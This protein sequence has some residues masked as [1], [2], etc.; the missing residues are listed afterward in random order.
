M[1]AEQTKKTFALKGIGVSPGVVIGRAY[2]FDPL[3]SQISFYKLKKSSSIPKEIQRFKKSLK[4]SEIQLL[5]IQENL[6]KSRITEPL[7]VIDVH[8]LILKDKKFSNRT[9]KYIRRLGINAE[10]A[11]RLTLDHYKQIFEGVGDAYIRD[12]ISDVQYVGQRILRNLSGEKREIVLEI[13]GEVIVIAPDLSPADTAQ[14]KMDKVIGFATDIGGRTS[15]TAIVSRAM[16]LPA[17]AG[18]GNI[19]QLV[20]T[21]DELIVDGIS[22]VV[23]VNPYPEMIKRYE[24][25]KL[26][27][28]AVN[29]EYMKYAK[30]PAVTTDDYLVQIGGNIEFVE[31][32]PSA[33]THG[34]EYIG[35]YRTEFL[36]I[37]R[38]DLP[39]EEDHFTNYRQVVSA[40]ELLWSTIRT[41]DLGGDKLYPDQKHVKELN[42][43]MGLRA[44]R[45]CLK[46]TELFKTQLRAIWRA[47]A[48]GKVKILFPMIAS[49]EEIREAKKLLEEARKELLEQGVEI[50]PKMEVGAM[51]EVPAAVEIADKLA[52]EVD[53]FSIGT[54]DL[55][56]YALAID[57]ANERLTY[58]YEPLH[59]AILRLIKRVVDAAHEVK[60]RVAM[61]GE[62]AGDPLYALILLG[63]ELDELSMNHL[64]IPRIKRIIRESSIKESKVL[65]EKA[66]TFSTATEVRAYVQDYMMGRFPDEFQKEV[67]QNGS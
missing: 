34:A 19:T 32:I 47:S 22:G 50:A 58:L 60:I 4:D 67:E 37:S 39:T 28:S 64:A 55:T 2:R 35:L 20:K 5:E 61:C 17:V 49:M 3:D 27:F 38:H 44:I 41:F 14:M 46:E 24:E 57:R 59:P 62:M 53:F 52:R 15:H 56:Q 11:V 33:I 12:R 54:N 29:D 30:L 7:Y 6:K 31:E 8:I 13:G 18:L 16:E 1:S 23:I 63:M 51:I 25:K 36:Y 43:Q 65:L 48:V 26:H 66:L 10:W 45:F 40:K 42:P 21:G 9:I